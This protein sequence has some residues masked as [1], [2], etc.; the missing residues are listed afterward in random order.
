MMKCLF[1]LLVLTSS[2]S[3]GQADSVSAQYYQGNWWLYIPRFAMIYLRIDGEKVFRNAEGRGTD[4]P[5][6]RCEFT[7]K[8]DTMI[9]S[10]KQGPMV[11]IYSDGR[12][13]LLEIDSGV[14]FS[15]IEERTVRKAKKKL[16]E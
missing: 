5:R 7:M 12:L 16:K 2:I 1:L 9:V 14:S 4:G 13:H 15:P 10:F 8:G 11:L 6:D 3:F